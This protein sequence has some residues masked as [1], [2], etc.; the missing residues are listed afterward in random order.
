MPQ[1]IILATKAVALG[2]NHIT[3]SVS[4]TGFPLHSKPAAAHGRYVAQQW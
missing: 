2:V 1:S 3:S 4:R